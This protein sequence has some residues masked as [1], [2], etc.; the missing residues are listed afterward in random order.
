MKQ[1]M[2]SFM[3]GLDNILQSAFG[4]TEYNDEMKPGY[5][6]KQDMISFMHGSVSIDI[7]NLQ[8]NDFSLLCII[9]ERKCFNINLVFVGFQDKE[10]N[11][12]MI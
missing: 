12:L 3:H 2:I 11:Q 8:I 6:M 10:N 9:V 4:L 1:D 7:I 5:I